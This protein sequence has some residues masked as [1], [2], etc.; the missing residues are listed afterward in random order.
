MILKTEFYERLEEAVK[1]Q[2]QG[3]INAH[4]HLDRSSTLDSRYLAHV[5]MDP[6]Q[7][8]AYPLWVKQDLTG[9]LH[10]GPAYERDD[11]KRRIGMQLDN[12]IA[13]AIKASSIFQG[14]A[15]L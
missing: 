12:L 13:A 14:F 10:R 15:G 1:R 4:L 6:L 11:L 9:D 7:A 5:G 8:S 2:P 3:I